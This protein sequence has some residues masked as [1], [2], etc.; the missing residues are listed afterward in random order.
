MIINT[1]EKLL[2]HTLALINDPDSCTECITEAVEVV[3]ALKRPGCVLAHYDT[4]CRH[5]PE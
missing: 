4:E 5:K 3:K 2:D 1:L